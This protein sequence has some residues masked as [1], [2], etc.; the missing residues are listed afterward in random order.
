MHWLWLCQSAMLVHFCWSS[1]L[2]CCPRPGWQHPTRKPNHS[3]CRVEIL[4]VYAQHLG[5]VEL[6]ALAAA[7]PGMAGRDLRDIC[8]QAE[9]RWASKII[10]GKAPKG[11]LP[12]VAEYLEA[13]RQRLRE[14][15]GLPGDAV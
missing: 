12:P 8:A 3:C 4:K 10:R 13:A 9:R 14:M 6:L 2:L 15:A 5:D 1:C 11:Q 7:T